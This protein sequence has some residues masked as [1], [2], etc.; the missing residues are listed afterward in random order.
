[1]EVTILTWSGEIWFTRVGASTLDG[2]RPETTSGPWSGRL[3][4]VRV[5][6]LALGVAALALDSAPTAC[7]ARETKSIVWIT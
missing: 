1:M 7:R 3:A 2:W 6:A 5:A 4:S